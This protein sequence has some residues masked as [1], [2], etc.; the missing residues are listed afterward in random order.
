MTALKI[1]EQRLKLAD[2]YLAAASTL[3]EAGGSTMNSLPVMFLLAHTLELL[4]KA[5]VKLVA[6]N[7]NKK[8]R[9]D[10]SQLWKRSKALGLLR[11]KTGAQ[12]EVGVIV[13]YL[14]EGHEG[15]QFRYS[16]KSLSHSGPVMTLDAIRKV[17]E[18]VWAEIAVRRQQQIEDAERQGM[19]IVWV[20]SGVRISI[21]R[22]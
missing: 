5:Y 20:P 3:M 10:L 18:A 1:A 9:H 19:R 14:K 21:E 12:A 22:D 11:A 2:E 6:P 15:Y 13:N 4:L 8:Y 16:E 7:D 17:R